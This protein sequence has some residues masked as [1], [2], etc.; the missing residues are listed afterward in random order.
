MLVR[1]DMRSGSSEAC[2]FCSLR[3]SIIIIGS[4]A[5]VNREKE[6]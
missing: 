1:D 6:V 4:P 5:Q 2:L 3:S